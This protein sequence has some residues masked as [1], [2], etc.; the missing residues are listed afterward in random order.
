MTGGMAS[1]KTNLNAERPSPSGL[2]MA[3]ARVPWARRT[4]LHPAHHG[5]LGD[6]SSPES[7]AGPA[8]DPVNAL[9]IS[10]LVLFASVVSVARFCPPLESLLFAVAL[11]VGLT[12]EF[13]SMITSVPLSVRVPR[14]SRQQVIVRRLAAPCRN[15]D[16]VD[17][18]CSGRIG[19]LTRVEMSVAAHVDAAAQTSSRV[20]LLAYLNSLFESGV[21]DP[22]TEAV[23][24]VFPKRPESRVAA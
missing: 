10:L 17:V 1:D 8:G 14:L 5:G 23:L 22:V 11:T 20:M 6:M 19:A 21:A 12:P 4:H 3:D 2:S 9:G 24:P 7:A 16:S 18:L 13:L 15:L